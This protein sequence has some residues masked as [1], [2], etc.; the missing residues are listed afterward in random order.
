MTLTAHEILHTAQIEAMH[1]SKQPDFE[2]DFL[3]EPKTHVRAVTSLEKEAGLSCEFEEKY[4]GRAIN[5]NDKNTC[6]GNVY[7]QTNS[8]LE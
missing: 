5:S 3:G 6:L 2:S 8:M 4:L 1:N 7:A